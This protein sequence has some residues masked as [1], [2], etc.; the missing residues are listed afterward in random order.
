MRR[1][2]VYLDDQLWETLRVRA[3]IEG[4]TVSTLASRAMREWH[5]QALARRMAAM[6][7]VV[8]CRRDAPEVESVEDEVRRL[9]SGR[10]GGGEW[11]AREDSNL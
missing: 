4:T 3:S 9:R 6:E 1:T 5:E 11:Y 8:G 2:R 7:A 10:V